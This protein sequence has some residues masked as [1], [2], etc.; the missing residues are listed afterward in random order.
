[1]EKNM[2]PFRAIAVAAAAVGLVGVTGCS[3]PSLLITPVGSSPVLEESL[4]DAGSKKSKIALIELEGMLAN[5]RA[6]SVLDRLGA[7]S[8]R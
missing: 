4:V 6:G 8:A 7:Q 2:R 5:T 1:M 3:L